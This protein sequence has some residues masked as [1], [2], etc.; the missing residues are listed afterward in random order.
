M[1]D[2]TV[3]TDD[4]LDTMLCRFVDRWRH[5]T[6]QRSAEWLKARQTSVGGSEVAALMGLNPYDKF[7]DIV[8]RK[9]GVAV[10]SA[11]GPPCW[12]GSMF[13]SAIEAYVEL[14][15]GLVLRGTDV[16]VPAPPASGLA[17]A[18]ANSPDGYGVA[19]LYRDDDGAWQL[20]TTDDDAA[21]RAAGRP[22]RR[23]A[24]LF[25][26]KCPYRR[27][28]KGAI[29]R[30]YRPQVWSGLALS[31]VASCGLFV[32]AV[33]RKCALWSL[34]GGP[35]YDRW[36][37]RERANPDWTTP[38]AWGLTG[39][40]APRL[41]HERRAAATKI[42]AE[43]VAENIDTADL[44]GAAGRSPA[45]EAWLVYRETLGSL[46]AERPDPVDLGDCETGAFDRVLAQID[47]GGFRAVHV[48]PCTAD[49]RGA[50]L[51]TSAE[52]GAAVDRLAAAAPRGHYLLGV[53]P[54]KLLEVSYTFEQRRP[55]FLAEVAPLVT[56]ALALAAEFRAADDP[57]AAFRAY[58]QKNARPT[59]SSNVTAAIRQDLF[60]SIEF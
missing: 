24:A 9:A 2:D 22:R 30:H 46:P 6:R 42:A 25:E 3:G 33:F 48:G 20:L 14:D 23:E 45:Y 1:T 35:G 38:V 60:D 52:I 56:R 49:G 55:G 36:Y 12:W 28:P 31:P 34:G 26:F 19:T 17:G 59:K 21:G 40:Y 11:A 7:D 58:A 8:A 5:R 39:V 41:E 54:W 16:N 13:E 15:C 53:I 57:A 50:P 44:A 27:R 47:T 18:H 43:T 37:H 29:P 10:R 51:R 4:A 32:D